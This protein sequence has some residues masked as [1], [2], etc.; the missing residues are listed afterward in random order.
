MQDQGIES[1]VHHRHPLRTRGHLLF[2]GHEPVP[3]R[4]LD[5]SVGGLCIVSELTLPVKIQGAI[6]L[7]LPA[8]NGRF[9]L[10][11]INIQVMH[12][13]F[14][15]REDGFKVGLLFL[16]PTLALLKMIRAMY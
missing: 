10:Q 6:A 8:G 13:I 15:N 12:S 3:V 4:T 9:E 11:N 5:I 1:R 14:C 7:S 16:K 2:S